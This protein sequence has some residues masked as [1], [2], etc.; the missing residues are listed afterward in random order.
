MIVDHCRLNQVFTPV[1]AAMPDEVS[2]LEQINKALGSC[3]EAIDLVNALF[4]NQFKRRIR[5]S[6]NHETDKNISL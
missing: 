3:Y 4:S 5:K 6:F 2:L 1:T